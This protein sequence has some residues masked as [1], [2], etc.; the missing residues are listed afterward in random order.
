M[1]APKVHAYARVCSYDWHSLDCL[2]GTKPPTPTPSSWPRL[3]I[4]SGANERVTPLYVTRLSTN[5]L[6]K[7][8]LER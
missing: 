1:I 8:K 2:P 5:R 7:V 4:H 6:A 3:A